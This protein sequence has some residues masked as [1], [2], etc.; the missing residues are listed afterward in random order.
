MPKT[1][2]FELLKP[3]ESD[4]ATESEIVV[5]FGNDATLRRWSIDAVVGDADC[6]QVDGAA[7]RWVDI[8]DDLLTAS[9]FDFDSDGQT[10]IVVRDGDAFLK[11]SRTELETYLAQPAGVTRLIIE[12]DSLASNT[13]IYKAVDK[14]HLLVRCTNANDAKQGVTAQTRKRFLCDVVAAKHQVKLTAT[15]AEALV[16]ILGDDIGMLETEI[17]KLGLYV[18][19]GGTIN[20]DLVRDVVAGW[21]G[22][23]VWQITDAIASGNASEA[24][25]QLDKLFGSGQRAI[26]LLPQIAWSLRR[27]GLTTAIIEHQERSGKSWRFDDALTA[28]GIRQGFQIQSAKKQLQAIGRARAKKLLPWLLDADLR[29]KGTHSSEGRDRMLLEQLVVRLAK[30]DAV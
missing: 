28:A 11:S 16:E 5:V 22:K 17:A 3:T 10:T 30:M 9:L 19:V 29:L 7:V 4:P 15:A 25:K 8:R 1:H 24:L 20:E 27:L 2:A 21:Q 18:S 14:H 23:T 12:L 26:A 13:R 6:R